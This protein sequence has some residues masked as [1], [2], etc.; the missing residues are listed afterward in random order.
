RWQMDNRPHPGQG[1]RCC[2]GLQRLARQYGHERL[3]AACT[4]AMAIHSPI[5]RSVNPI[6]ASGTDRQPLPAQ[7]TQTSLP[8]HENVRGPDYYH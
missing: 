2:L 7:P 4:R 1:Y 6:L 3:E 5:Y 8:L